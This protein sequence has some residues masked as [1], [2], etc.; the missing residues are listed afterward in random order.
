MTVS[1]DI[2]NGILLE[3]SDKFCYLG[4]MLSACEAWVFV[5]VSDE[6]S[7]SVKECWDATAIML[8]TGIFGMQKS[9]I[10]LSK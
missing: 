1:L 3:K 9:Y 2:G 8:N 7:Y 6:C 5:C 4:Y 10:H